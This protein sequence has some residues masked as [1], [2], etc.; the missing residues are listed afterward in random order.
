MPASSISL[1]RR[2]FGSHVAAATIAVV[3]RRAAAQDAAWSMAT[4]YPATTVSGEGIG[5]FTARAAKESSGRLAIKPAYD[6]PDGLKS[7]D[8]VAAIRDG[9]LGAGDSFAGAIGRIDPVFALSSLPFVATSRAEARRLLEAARGLYALRFARQKQRLLYAT[10]WPPSGLWAKKPIVTMADLAGLPLRVYDAAGLAVFAAAGARAANLSFADT[11]PRVAD[12][13]IEAVLSSGDGGAGRRL[14]EHLPYFTEIGYAM[15][16][17]FATLSQPLY[18][19]LAA[20]LRAAVD[21]SAEATQPWL[22]ELLTRRL[23]ENDARLRA[24]KVTIVPAET[25][26]TEF[27]AALVKAATSAIDEW[28]HQAGA[29]SAAV[30]AAVGR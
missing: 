6:A 5:F 30:L 28:K 15:P 21:A 12:G 27:R 19:S 9:R 13:S 26:S 4:E 16:L 3:A 23:E 18:D 20:D 14:W 17:S 8:I 2:A 10:P 22:W 24:N 29:D 7:I 1:S 11:M 25:I